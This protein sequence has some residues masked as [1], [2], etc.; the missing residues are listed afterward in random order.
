MQP[1]IYR[2]QTMELCNALERFCRRPCIL[3][4]VGI[5]RDSFPDLD[6]FRVDESQ[7]M[8]RSNNFLRSVSKVERRSVGATMP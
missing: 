7:T 3:A 2:F 6:A 1:L 5:P 4:L 8:M